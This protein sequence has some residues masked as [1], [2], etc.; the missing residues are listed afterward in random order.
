M[1][2]GVFSIARLA[3]SSTV[4]SN[5]IRT[6]YAAPVAI[7]TLRPAPGSRHTQKRLGRGQGSGRGGTSTRGH[8]GQKARS[9]NGKPKAGFEGGQTPITRRFPKRGFTNV[10]EKTFAPINLDRLQH[11]IDSNRL[12]STPDRPITAR[13]LLYSGCIHDVKDGVK[14]LG[15][16]AAYLKSPVF[17]EV[18]RASQSAIKA[19]EK[20][21]GRVTCKFYND[22]ALKDCVDG[23]T[24]RKSAL[25]VRK[26]DILWYTRWKNRGY[27][28]DPPTSV[29]SSTTSPASAP[30]L[31]V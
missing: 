30:S 2:G 20:N 26:N 29:S 7:H 17:L 27:L 24:D 12:V 14:L 3:S 4:F 22:L 10:S 15:D 25:P 21:G 6:V 16:G 8:K 1:L 11:W 19:I 31:S 9:G 23:R 5:S 18:S 13:E 28:A